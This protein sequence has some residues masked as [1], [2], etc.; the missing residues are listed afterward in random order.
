MRHARPVCSRINPSTVNAVRS[1]SEERSD[2][3]KR[4]EALSPPVA[5]EIVRRYAWLRSRLGAEFGDRPLVLPTAAFFPDVF[6]PDEGSLQRLTARMQHHAGMRDVPI[7]ARVIETEPTGL[8]GGCG[9]PAC[10]PAP[11][12]GDTVRL[13]ETEEGW[14]ISIPDVELQHPTALTCNLARVLGQVALVESSQ[15]PSD[16]EAPLEVSADLAAVQLGL[17]TLLLQ[18]SHIYSKSCGG[19][20]IA[21]LTALGPYE[22][23]LSVVLFAEVSG[24]RWQAARKG[25]A[26]TQVDALNAAAEIVG[27]APRLVERV[28]TAPATLTAPGSIELTEQRSWLSKIFSRPKKEISAEALL[29]AALAG[30]PVDDTA[31]RA[32]RAG[33][34]KVLPVKTQSR[35]QADDELKALVEEALTVGK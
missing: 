9:G 2:R 11:G 23:A 16:V 17:G 12:Q 26:P 18:G 35:S 3:L 14:L 7:M 29:E 22:L 34:S 4:M 13:A 25:M 24:Q 28:R 21:R 19:P 6:R 33:T 5:T 30:E 20:S 8:P 1:T 27:N 31:L 10:S 15:S 32:L